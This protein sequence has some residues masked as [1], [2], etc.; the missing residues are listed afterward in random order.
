MAN[1]EHEGLEKIYQNLD[2]PHHQA[3]QNVKTE[4]HRPG[5]LALGHRSKS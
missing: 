5:A 1:G 3:A 2:C 4:S